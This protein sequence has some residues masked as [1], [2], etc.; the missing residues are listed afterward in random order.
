MTIKRDIT[1][2]VG[3]IYLALVVLAIVVFGKVVYLQV[4]EG[5]KWRSM[6]QVMTSKEREI[7]ANRGNIL[8]CDGRKLACSVPSYRLYMDMMAHGLTDEIFNENIDSL[9]LCLS[10]FFKDKSTSAYKRDLV[11]ARQKH[12]RYYR[13][14]RRRISFTELKKVKEFPIFRLGKNTGGFL[15]EMLDQRKLPFGIL[16]SRTIGKLYEEKEKGGMVGLERA[17]DDVLKGKNGV[18]TFTRISG[19]WVPEE[20]MPPQN[21]ND[22]LTSIDIEIQDVAENSLKQQLVKHNA[23]H[24]SAI[25][26]EVQTGEIKAIVNLYRQSPGNY[27]EDYFNYAIGEATEPGSTFKLVS[28]MVALE[29]GLLNLDDS[30]DTG[31]GYCK[32]Y[33]RV[34]RDSHHGGFG[35]ITYRQ[36][37]EKSSNV[38]VSK[39]IVDRYKSNPKKYIDRIYSM[40]LNQKNGLEIKGEGEPFIKYPGSDTWS[41][42][43]LPWIS[44]GYESQLTPLQILTFYNAVAN[45]GKMVKPHFVK[46]VYRHGELTESFEPTVINPSICSLSTIEKV[47]ELLVGVVEH[48]TAQNLKN[49]NYKIAGKTGTAQ[50]AKGSSGYKGGSGVEYQASFAGYFPADRPKYS[51]IVV[52]NGPSNNVYYGNVVAGTVFKDIA[53]RVYATSLEM[54]D[55]RV[56]KVPD[57]GVLPYSKGGTKEDL[58][59]VFDRL[60]VT[61]EG[62]DVNSDWISTTAQEYK[63]EFARKTFSKGLVPNVKGMGAKDAVSLLENMGLKV[64]V[65]GRGRVVEQSVTAGSRL[66]SGTRIFIKLG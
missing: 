38:G 3:V 26:M 56:E 4:V 7:E 53:D 27:V 61:V 45:N 19:H 10:S 11:S 9:S 63:V 2:R 47:H 30:I 55:E 24:G 58:Q 65:S 32:F 22:I 16:A 35:K 6:E 13:I 18:S 8:A 31:K 1:W 5:E 12:K 14:N 64:I 23:D 54:M 62:E 20:V 51:C 52:V 33:D 59:T 29:D 43:S 42:V 40:G 28:M 37:F 46:G 44:I 48:G 57:S 36:V 21:G 50:I 34:M 66:K 15:P 49:D 17:Y 60:N 39:M 25:L 41:G